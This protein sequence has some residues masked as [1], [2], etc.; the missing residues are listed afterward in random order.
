MSNEPE[1]KNSINQKFTIVTQENFDSTFRLKATEGVLE[2]NNKDYHYACQEGEQFDHI[3]IFLNIYGFLPA[4]G[5]L[6]KCDIYQL[7]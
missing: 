7:L 4:L 2:F 6:F 1:V 3:S 5:D